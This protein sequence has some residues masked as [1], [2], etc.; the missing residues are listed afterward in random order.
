MWQVHNT[1]NVSRLK[2]CRIDETRPQ[3]PPPPLRSTA[4]DQQ[5]EVE[6]IRMHKGNTVRDLQYEVKWMGYP[7]TDNTCEP[8][9]NLKSTSTELLRD[10]HQARGLRVYAWMT[11]PR[12]D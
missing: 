11:A 9:A 3:Q 7:A 5:W 6:A 4:R 8:L 12:I 1:F 2:H 10:Y